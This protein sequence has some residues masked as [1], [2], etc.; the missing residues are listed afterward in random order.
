LK[1][2]LHTAQLLGNVS[3]T[4]VNFLE[5]NRNKADLKYSR[6]ECMGWLNCRNYA[7]E[8]EWFIA[9]YVVLAGMYWLHVQS[10]LVQRA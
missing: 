1:D 7:E 10:A 9:R 6:L 3:A 8:V 5:S 4:A 2:E